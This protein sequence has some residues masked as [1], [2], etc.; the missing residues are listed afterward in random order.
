MVD[1]REMLE[2][3]HRLGGSVDQIFVCKSARTQRIDFHLDEVFSLIV[4]WRSSLD[5]QSAAQDMSADKA[6]NRDKATSME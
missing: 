5:R 6:A 3:H 2:T 1:A 4:G